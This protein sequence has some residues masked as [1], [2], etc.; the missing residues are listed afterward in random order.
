VS[1]AQ[2]NFQ[3]KAL[4]FPSKTHTHRQTLNMMAWYGFKT[5]EAVSQPEHIKYSIIIKGKNEKGED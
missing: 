1:Q 5:I 2:G 4:K 3:H